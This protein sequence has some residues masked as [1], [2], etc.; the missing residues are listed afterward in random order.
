MVGLG[1]LTTRSRQARLATNQFALM[2]T[3]LDP[4]SDHYFR[5]SQA[6]LAEIGIELQLTRL[7]GH[8][9]HVTICQWAHRNRPYSDAE[10]KSWARAIFETLPYEVEVAL[11]PLL[12]S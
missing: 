6:T 9:A 1:L 5:T 8:T 10:L 12:G 3:N 4:A 7:Q 2:I 11:L